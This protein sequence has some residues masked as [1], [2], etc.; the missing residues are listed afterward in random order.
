VPLDL[1][2]GASRDDGTGGAC[3]WRRKRKS[4]TCR[5]FRFSPAYANTEGAALAEIATRNGVAAASDVAS[6]TL[7]LLAKIERLFEKGFV[8]HDAAAI[9]LNLR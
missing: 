2:L 6:R 7:S 4:G 5:F 8:R 9:C 1:A 3:A